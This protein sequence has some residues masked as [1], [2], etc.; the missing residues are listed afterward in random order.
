MLTA[1]F[2]R[3]FRETRTPP[4]LAEQA[5]TEAQHL[6]DAGDSERCAAY[7]QKTL[8]QADNF[9]RLS[10]ILCRALMRAGNNPAAR[11]ALDTYLR[12]EAAGDQF[13]L[14]YAE[15]IERAGQTRDAA[16]L[17]NLAADLRPDSSALAF[18]AGRL[19]FIEK[20]INTSVAYLTKTLHVAKYRTAALRLLGCAT[21]ECNQFAAS[22]E[23]FQ[24]L[25]DDAPSDPEIAFWLSRCKLYLRD[26]HGARL[27]LES[28]IEEHP[29]DSM[30]HELLGYVCLTQGDWEEGFKQF[31]YRLAAFRIGDGPSGARE[32]LELLDDAL[33]GIPEWEGRPLTG[34]RILVWME[35]GQGDAI[36]LLRLVSALRTEW[37]AADVAF[38][39]GASLQSLIEEGVPGIRFIRA[40]TTWRPDIGEFDYQ[41]SIM[42]LPHLMG[43]TPTKIPG[44]SPYIFIPEKRRKHWETTLGPPRC[45]RVGIAWAGNPQHRFDSLR[46]IH[47]EELAPVLSLTAIEFISLQKDTPPLCRHS[48]DNLSK[49]WIEKCD[50]FMDTAALIDNLDLVVTIDSA[51]AHL[52]GAVGIPVWLLNRYESEWRWMLNRSDSVWYPSMRIFNQKT[53][54]DWKPVVSE[55]AKELERLTRETPP[56][57]KF[58]R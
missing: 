2:S 5:E 35:Q 31:E 36:M 27:L 7:C 9:L 57:F 49:Q 16:D 33:T 6:L 41:C 37:H 19:A 28:A 10:P 1:L 21:F 14:D 58:F 38:L 34:K 13:L 25:A 54:R 18:H 22:H 12:K 51:V 50:N 4:D 39:C 42:S 17:V 53:S 15:K 30:L 20:R 3:L 46:S 56:P 23:Y 24:Q 11:E 29:Q 47:L 45:L 48:A 52:A 43:I 26:I 44:T 8:A 40:T 55:V 32:W